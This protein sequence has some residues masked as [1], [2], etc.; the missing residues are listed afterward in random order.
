M[1]QGSTFRKMGGQRNLLHFGVGITLIATSMLAPLVSP[2]LALVLL[3]VGLFFIAWS[4]FGSRISPILEKSKIGR[5]IMHAMDYVSALTESRDE[6]YWTRMA[7]IDEVWPTLKPEEK[8]VLKSLAIHGVVG[9]CDSAT[10]VHLLQ[11]NLVI[12][13]F[14]FDQL[15]LSAEFKEFIINK[16]RS[17]LRATSNGE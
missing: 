10:W 17:E 11:K 15:Y 5:S 8:D 1:G 2:Y 3:A 14:G 9:R 16:V 13:R 7:R 6:I 12:G 4:I